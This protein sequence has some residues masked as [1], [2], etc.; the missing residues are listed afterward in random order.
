MGPTA[1]A[2]ARS[3]SALAARLPVEIVSVDSA[4]VYRGMDIG[5][6]K[7][8]AATRARVPHHLIDIIDPD[9]GLFG[10]ALSRRCARGDRRDPRARPH[11]AARRRHDALLQGAAR[12]PVGP[13]AG[14]RRRARARSTPRAAEL[15][16]AGAA[17]RARARRSARPRRA[18]SRPTRSASSA[19]SRSHESTGRPLSALQGAREGAAAPGLVV[20]RADPAGPGAAA[21]AHRRALRRDARSRA[22]RRA[23]G[24]A[25]SATALTPIDAVDALRRLSAGL[26]VPRRRRRPRALRER[27]RRGDAPARQA[28]VDLAALDSGAGAST[29]SRPAS[30]ATSPAGFAARAFAA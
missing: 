12:R 16:L 7:P 15:G 2:R 20:A 18:S 23:R 17:R 26:A 29:P 30:P 28:P 11:A 14:R 9:R 19:R 5:T 4:Q 21:P 10:R 6:A 22:G 13:A 25:R 8:D 1:A 24:L 3:R 27:G